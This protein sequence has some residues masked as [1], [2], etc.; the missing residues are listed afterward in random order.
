[1]YVHDWLRDKEAEWKCKV[2]Q[3]QFHKMAL[4]AFQSETRSITLWMKRVSPKA[5]TKFRWR[6]RIRCLLSPKGNC[7]L[8]KQNVSLSVCC[9]KGLGIGCLLAATSLAHSGLKP[10]GLKY[11]TEA[12]TG[13]V[14]QHYMLPRQINSTNLFRYFCL[15][16]LTFHDACFEIETLISVIHTPP[17]GEELTTIPL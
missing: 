9:R 16:K 13:K 11:I 6:C 7:S 15:S 2:F 1:M 8:Q 12:Q 17:R 14:T 5:S 10:E 3:H 4:Q